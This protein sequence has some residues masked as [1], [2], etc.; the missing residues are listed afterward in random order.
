[1]KIVYGVAWVN[2]K[3]VRRPVLIDNK[4]CEEC[5]NEFEPKRQDS[6]YCSD[7]CAKSAEYKRNAV[8]ARERALKWYKNN[9]DKV[10]VKRKAIYWADPEKA[11]VKAKEW[12]D[13]NAARAKANRT[14]YKDEIRHGGKRAEIIIKQKGLCF[15]CNKDTSLGNKNAH[16]HH[17]NFDSTD[18]EHQVLVCNSCHAKIHLHGHSLKK[19]IS[20]TTT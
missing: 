4:K 8:K 7:K 15:M 2:G 5:G 20:P 17:Y 11:K 1:M 12:R 14:T 16:L 6:R 13:T 18:H 3:K 10:R 19:Y 9:I